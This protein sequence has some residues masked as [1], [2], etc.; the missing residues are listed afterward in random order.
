MYLNYMNIELVMVDCIVCAIHMTAVI[1]IIQRERVPMEW[2]TENVDLSVLIP[3]IAT[4]VR[5]PVSHCDVL[6]E[7]ASALTIM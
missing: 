4:L 5:T 2:N 7:V 1:I 6:L 3:V